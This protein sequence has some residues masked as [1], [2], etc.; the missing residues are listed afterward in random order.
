MEAGTIVEIVKNLL[1]F[2]LVKVASSHEEPAPLPASTEAATTLSGPLW[3]AD[4][5]KVDLETPAVAR[6]AASDMMEVDL[7]TPAVPKAPATKSSSTWLKVSKKR[8]SP[9]AP[10]TQQPSTSEKKFKVVDRVR[11]PVLSSRIV[12]PHQ[13]VGAARATF[14][15]PLLVVAAEGAKLDALFYSAVLPQEDGTLKVQDDRCSLI[16]DG[17]V[18]FWARESLKKGLVCELDLFGL[19][20]QG[21]AVELWMGLAFKQCPA[22]TEDALVDFLGGALG[23][24][25]M[26]SPDSCSEFVAAKKQ[27][28]VAFG[29][30]DMEKN[31]ESVFSSLSSVVPAARQPR[32]VLT[33]LKAHQLTALG[34]MLSKEKL[35]DR[36]PPF[37]QERAEFGPLP[38]RASEAGQWGT[39]HFQIVLTFLMIV[40]RFNRNRPYYARFPKPL[41]SVIFSQV[42]ILTKYFHTLTNIET[43]VE[44]QFVSFLCL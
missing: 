26:K 44:A 4:T 11:P 18:T 19:E 6:A 5:M 20:E 42:P 33:Q 7:E 12:N 17:K 8:D 36:L 34:W 35:R 31:L 13:C 32:A 15:V 25:L 39:K 43:Q 41:L 21:D 1:S 37:W 29:G 10:M 22:V 40:A 3:S 30:S 16:A 9:A 14:F 27:S 2:K 23:D 28:K 38:W 24:L